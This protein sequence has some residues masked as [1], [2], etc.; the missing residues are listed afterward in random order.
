VGA[1]RLSRRAEADLLSIGT[2]TL[3]RWGEAQTVRYLDELE[4]CCRQ[5]ADN[6]TSGRACDYVRPGLYRS[7]H[8]LN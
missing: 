7:D 4:D 5:L 2:Y 1:F 8:L 6:V 3:R